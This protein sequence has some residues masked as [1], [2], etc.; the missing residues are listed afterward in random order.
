MFAVSLYR[1]ADHIIRNIN[2]A[3][4]AWLTL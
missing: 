2:A 1:H 4:G 3:G